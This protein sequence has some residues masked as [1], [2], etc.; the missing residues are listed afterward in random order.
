MKTLLSFLRTDKKKIESVVDNEEETKK[1]IE[2]SKYIE[3]RARDEGRTKKT[4]SFFFIVNYL[5]SIICLFYN[6]IKNVNEKNQIVLINY[7]V[8]DLISEVKDEEIFI[9]SHWCRFQT[10]FC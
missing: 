4:S 9:F 8:I 5:S 1:I 3:R 10:E 2:L 7:R 6:K